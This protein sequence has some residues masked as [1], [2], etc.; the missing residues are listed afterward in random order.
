[1]DACNSEKAN[2]SGGLPGRSVRGGTI[3][4]LIFAAVFFGLLA[5]GV[6]WILKMVGQAGQQYSTA[7]I[8]TS[9]KAS[10][11]QCQNNLRT[12]C[13]AFTCTP[14]VTKACRRRSRR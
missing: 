6:L 9:Q 7:M 10:A 2:R 8:Q 11:L 3:T 1:M 4:N 12:I 14:S 13:R 5:L